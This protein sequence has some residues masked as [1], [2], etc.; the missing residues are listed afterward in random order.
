MVKPLTNLLKKEDLISNTGYIHPTLET[1]YVGDRDPTFP[2]HFL[3]ELFKQG[4]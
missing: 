3:P 2:N 4:T 1:L